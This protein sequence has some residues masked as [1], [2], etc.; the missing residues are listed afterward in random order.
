MA[1][2]AKNPEKK[3]FQVQLDAKLL[4]EAQAKAKAEDLKLTQVV[5][6][7]LMDYVSNPQ[8]KLFH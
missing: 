5:R 3:N 2:I 7:F 8:G 4:H 1:K 6:R